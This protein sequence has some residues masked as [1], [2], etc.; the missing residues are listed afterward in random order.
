MGGDPY[1]HLPV[2]VRK[3]GR[4]VGVGFDVSCLGYLRPTMWPSVWV[5]L[6]TAFSMTPITELLARSSLP[7]SFGCSFLSG[8]PS[9]TRLLLL[10]SRLSTPAGAHAANQ[11]AT[12]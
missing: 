8:A 11:A 2:G 12:P 1:V 3:P 9:E 4:L 7:S 6:A 5:I 10:S